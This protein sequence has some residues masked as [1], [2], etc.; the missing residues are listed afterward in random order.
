MKPSELIEKYGWVQRDF[1]HVA[2]GFCIQ[3]AIYHAYGTVGE[4]CWQ[5][6]ADIVGERVTWIGAW[7]DNPKRTKEEVIEALKKWE[8]HYETI[9]AH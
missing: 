3:G 7:N 2:Y 1:G 9:A 8:A 4:A 6:L 5:A